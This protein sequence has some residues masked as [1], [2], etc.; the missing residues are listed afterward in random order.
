MPAKPFKQV[1][2]KPQQPDCCLE[3][4]LLG[5]IPPGERKPKSQETLVCLGT[6]HA[7]NARIARSRASAHDSKHPLKRWC[8]EDWER[9]Q[10]DPYFGKLPVRKI[11]ISR[12]RDPWER[13]QQLPIIFHE[14]RGPKPK[15]K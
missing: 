10:E 6:R 1:E 8:D 3:C 4:P 13:S 11:D 9:W 5:Q 15:D 2:L 12:Y 14:K 7:L